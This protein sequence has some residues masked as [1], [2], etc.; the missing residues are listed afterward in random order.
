MNDFENKIKGVLKKEVEK[1]LSYD[2]AIKNAFYNSKNKRKSNLLLKLATTT[3]CLIMICTGVFATSYIVYEKVWKKP[4]IVNQE[5]EN[6]NVEKEI[7]KEEKENYIS[8]EDAIKI[9]N[10]VIN[11]LDYKNIQIS[12]VDLKRKYNTEYSGHYIL[13][14][15]NILITINAETGKLEY[16]GDSSIND[17]DIKCDEISEEQV[18]KIAREI[19]NKLGLFDN[20]NKYE[21]VNTK[22]ADIAFGEHINS[23]WEVSFGKMYNGTYDKSNIS[24]ICFS[25]CDNN[26]VISS[27]TF[28]D[29]NNF[30]NNPIIITKEEAIEIANAHLNEFKEIALS[31]IKENGYNYDVNISI[32]NV[33]FPT[34]TYGDI[35]LPEGYYDALRIKIGKAEGKNWWCVMFPPLCFVD[36]QNNVIDKETDEKLKKVLT[37]DEYELIVEKDKKNIN[38]LQIKFKIVEVFQK[39]LNLEKEDKISINN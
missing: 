6:S 26:I 13:R 15:N 30:E 12:N 21:I 38:N 16:F 39:I 3:S 19:Y 31:T 2:Y 20:E 33:F 36:E 8:E 35:S 23:L 28:I 7:S 10:E 25:I 22:K 5:E 18:N 17:R 9:A 27:I 14:S 32:D 4:V 1:P 24:T 11:K 34:K 37:K 29:N